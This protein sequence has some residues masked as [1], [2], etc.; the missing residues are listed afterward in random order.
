MY[1]S[2]MVESSRGHTRARW[3]RATKGWVALVTFCV[4]VVAIGIFI[5]A[6]PPS[7]DN[8]Q[9]PPTNSGTTSQITVPGTPASGLPALA[10]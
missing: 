3:S 8:K 4:V 10:R 7:T 6:N 1:R 2:E 9:P 5:F